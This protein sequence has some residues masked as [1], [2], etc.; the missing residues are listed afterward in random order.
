MNLLGITCKS[1]LSLFAVMRLTQMRTTNP[2]SILLF[3]VFFYIYMKLSS[4][5]TE[6]RMES[7][8]S[9]YSGILSGL[10][11]IF[12]LAASYVQLYGSM[13]STLFR[14]IILL[15]SAAGLALLYYHAILCLLIYSSQVRIDT[16]LYPVSWLPYA[17]FGACMLFWLPYYLHEYPG[18]MTPDSINQYAQIIGTY[19][20]SN[21]HSV[22]HTLLIGYF[23]HLGLNLTGSEYVGLGLYTLFQMCFMAFTAGYV[24]RT[25]Q[26]AGIL[27]P[28]CIGTICFY[29]LMPY[30][31]I[32]A[33]T[34]WKDI[35]FAGCMTLFV[36]A[37]IRLLVHEKSTK[38][39]ISE[40]FT[41]LLPYT[42]SGIMLCLLRTNGWYAF[43]VTLPFILFMYRDRLR[44]IIPANVIILLIVLF[45]KYPCMNVYE[46]RQAD[47]AEF[48]SIP[49]QQLARVV[50]EQ[51]SLTQEQTQSLS[52]FMDIDQIASLYQP[53]VSDP[54]KNLIRSTSG[55]Y[56]D[57]HKSEFFSLWFSVGISHLR[58]YFDAYVAQTHGFWYPDASYEVG[59]SDG[60]YPN[61]FGLTW[62]PLLKGS[63]V[64]KIREIL[65]K[66]WELIP[67]FG[68]LWSM[69]GM[70][71]LILIS[72]VLCLRQ[73]QSA[74][75]VLMIPAVA[76]VLTLCIATPVA[77]EFRYAY[78]L[79]H[80]LPLY[81]TLPF[82][83]AA[84]R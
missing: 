31:G 3:A 10:F 23:Y 1:F 84:E 35:P 4:T 39:K 11:T 12:T 67:L 13:T 81:L 62:Q 75:A 27:T 24:V 50:A 42:I 14:L 63:L 21:Y 69:G 65:F 46:I 78:A 54:V 60:I 56:L 47:F 48:V 61:E 15:L 77:T 19:E 59:L 8:D 33:V 26:K 25:M 44:I 7:R 53:E 51:E 22:I 37:L 30:H 49:V 80:G 79:F 55:N 45:I 28:V 20:L 58:T 18:V 34:I 32:Y 74:N 6:T 57:N 73:S 5:S 40:Y 76:L 43:L 16:T 41:I 68:F 82:I 38:L 9:L 71:W 2:V 17:A 36:A 70:F 66:L 64:V 29:A 72:Q 83:R 52:H